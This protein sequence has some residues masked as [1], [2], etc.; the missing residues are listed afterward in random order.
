MFAYAFTL[1]AVVVL[2]QGILAVY[3]QGAARAAADE[4]VR[5]GSR[6]SAGMMVCEAR[7]SEVMRSLL[8][9]TAG[10][11]TAVS[12]AASGSELVST[13]RVVFDSPLPGVPTFTLEGVGRAIQEGSPP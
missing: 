10:S 13:V 11:D 7:A 6:V 3:I 5:A 12:C 4:G 1:V 2:L 8:S 9:G